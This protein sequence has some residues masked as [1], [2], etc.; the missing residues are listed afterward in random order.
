MCI[1]I[2]DG[3]RGGA[4]AAHER[5]SKEKP[6]PRVNPIPPSH[7]SSLRTCSAARRRWGP[8]A[9]SPRLL[10]KTSP[11]TI[12]PS[13]PPVSLCSSSA[14]L[15]W[16]RKTPRPRPAAARQRTSAATPSRSWVCRKPALRQDAYVRHCFPRPHVSTVLGCTG[17]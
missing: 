2:Q 10:C 15:Q 9:R 4:R 17:G 1:Y 7:P 5:R 12:S 14:A 13:H 8:L 16:R 11:P 3:S 6:H